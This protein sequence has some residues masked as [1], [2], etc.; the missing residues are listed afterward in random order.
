MRPHGNFRS[1][2][3]SEV[4]NLYKKLAFVDILLASDVQTNLPYCKAKFLVHPFNIKYSE[5]FNISK[6]RNQLF[7]IKNQEKKN[8]SWHC[9]FNLY[10]RTWKQA[11]HF[12]KTKHTEAA[13]IYRRANMCKILHSAVCHY[14][15]KKEIKI[16]SIIRKFRMEHLESHVWLP[17]SSYMVKY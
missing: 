3:A 4:E 16:S 1:L 10:L 14:T 6:R 2:P 5:K 17:A 11:I 7:L 12:G 13:F 9:P 15:D 8:I